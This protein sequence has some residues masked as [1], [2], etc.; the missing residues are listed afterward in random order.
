MQGG[1]GGSRDGGWRGRR[2]R[3]PGQGTKET[4]QPDL[5]SVCHLPWGLSD[6]RNDHRAAPRNKSMFLF[7]PVAKVGDAAPAG[8]RAPLNAPS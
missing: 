6:L 3:Q 7:M 5:I 4:P 1:I 8:S 2:W